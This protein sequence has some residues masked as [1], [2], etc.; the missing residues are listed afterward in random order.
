MNNV[1]RPET[2][3]IPAP[4]RVNQATAFAVSIIVSI[5]ASALILLS[6]H[7]GI[8]CSVAGM[9]VAAVVV[10]TWFGGMGPGFL[11]I[12]LLVVLLGR[13]SQPASGSWFHLLVLAIA[14][15]LLCRLLNWRRRLFARL[16]VELI[17][18]RK[19]VYWAPT[20]LVLFGL[21]RTIQFFNPAFTRVYG[22]SLEELRGKTF[23]VPEAES[24]Q[25]HALLK[26][27]QGGGSFLNVPTKRLRKDGSE[28]RVVIS[29]APVTDD[30]GNPAA[31]VGLALEAEPRPEV[32][33]ERARLEFLVQ[34]SS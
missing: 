13:F 27:V 25:W 24:D 30:A 1:T 10:S 2:A 22:W 11:T 21:D 26:S 3:V 20:P 8:P 23:P 14:N 12:V 17:Q 18:L 9:F 5:I 16:V 6:Q 31:I 4:F 29:G 34:H 32:L 28:V 33:L 15:G 7:Y 19:I